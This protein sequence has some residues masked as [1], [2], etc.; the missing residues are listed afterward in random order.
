[1]SENRD[2]HQFGRPLQSIRDRHELVTV[3]IFALTLPHRV[4][5]VSSFADLIST[6]FAGDINALCWPRQLPGDFQEIINQLGAGEGMTTI[7]DDDLRALTLS[8]AGTLARAALLADQ[9]LL[10]DHGLAPILDCITGYPS[11]GAAGPIPTDVY[12]F[13]VDSAPVQAD[14]YLCTY[15]G[16]P[17]E[18]LVNEFAIRRI[19]VAETRAEL[20]KAYGG[21]DDAAFAAD[22]SEKCFDLHYAQRSGSKPYSFGLG[23]LWRIAIAYPGSP[24]LPCIHRAP[25][26]PPG[27]PARLL[28]IS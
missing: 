4:R 6:P 11:D 18:G 24:V 25:L 20:V 12:S 23:N 2:S 3:P 19:D 14:T 27:A 28:L 13:H 5:I 16:S 15:I 21:P 22:L 9:A 8:P 17:S 7:E 1:V 26:A 10:R